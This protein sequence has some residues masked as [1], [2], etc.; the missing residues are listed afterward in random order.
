MRPLEWLDLGNW[1]RDLLRLVEPPVLEV[2][3]GTGA[4]LASYHGMKPVAI[5]LNVRRMHKTRKRGIAHD[6]QATLI[7]MDVLRLAFP[8]STFASPVTSLVLCSLTDLVH[9]L[10]QL[11]GPSPTG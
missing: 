1:P 2:G 4:S 6:S 3:V 11:L 10:R 8:D 5:D 9:G 7:Q